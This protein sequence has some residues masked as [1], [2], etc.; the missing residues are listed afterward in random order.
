MHFK[1]GTTTLRVKFETTTTLADE[2]P[3]GFA[4]WPG[5]ME[6]ARGEGD[7]PRLDISEATRRSCVMRPKRA[8]STFPTSYLDE[9]MFA[10]SA[11]TG[12]DSKLI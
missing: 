8:V 11:D 7:R 10:L 4:L 3:F 12:S 6:R 1:W 5:D 9:I 2:E